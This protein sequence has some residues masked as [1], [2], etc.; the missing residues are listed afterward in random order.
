MST[1]RMS[2]SELKV[3]LMSDFV[4]F[5]VITKLAFQ[6]HNNSPEQFSVAKN[7]FYA[8][9]HTGR[10]AILTVLSAECSHANAVGVGDLLLSFG[11]VS[12]TMMTSTEL[13]A[14]LMTN[15]GIFEVVS[16]VAFQ[17]INLP[18]QLSVA[19]MGSMPKDTEVV[20]LF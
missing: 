15:F 11:G 19:K 1:A 10:A 14:A 6:Y 13:D 5:E 9:G 8:S 17:Y 12:T 7:G 18:E 4:N 3:A 2:S 16:K 20:M